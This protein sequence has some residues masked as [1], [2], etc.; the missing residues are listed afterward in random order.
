MT[1]GDKLKALRLRKKLTQKEVAK[2]LGVANTR[3][4]EWERGVRTPKALTQEAIFSRLK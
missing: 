1:F 3:I 2:K 4:S